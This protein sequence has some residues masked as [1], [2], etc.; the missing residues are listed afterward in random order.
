MDFEAWTVEL[1]GRS[2]KHTSGFTVRVAGDPANP[3][4]VTPGRFPQDLSALDQVRLLRCGCEAIANHARS[5]RGTTRH[6]AR[7]VTSSNVKPISRVD[8]SKLSLKPKT[9]TSK[10]D[11][12]GHSQEA[13]TETVD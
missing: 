10:K 1:S 7:R 2:A 12:V 5:S 6:P 8:R 3:Y 13:P 9:D 11:A 4:E